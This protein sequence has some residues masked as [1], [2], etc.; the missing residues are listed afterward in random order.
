MKYRLKG[1][2]TIEAALI[3]PLIMTVIVF[4]IYMSF[5]LHDRA[6]MSACAYQAALK[7]SLIR[8]GE[9]DMKAEAERAAGYSIEGL[10]LATEYPEITVTVSRKKVHIQY[11]GNMRI[12]QSIL[13]F[14]IHG[15]DH[16]EVSGGAEASEKDAIEFIRQCRAAGG[17]IR[18]RGGSQ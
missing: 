18:K 11:T 12:P 3:L 5:F 9:E 17:I 2:Y 15:T 1:S 4:I 10:L 14:P 16:I 13:F 6:V 7:A 8:T